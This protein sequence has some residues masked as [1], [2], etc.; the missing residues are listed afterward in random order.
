[1]T[2]K[3]N[4]TNAAR[5]LDRAHISYRLIP[6][7]V[8]PD[9]LAADHVAAELGEPIERVFKTIVLKGMR[10]GH[11]VCVVPGNFEVSLKLAAEVMHDKSAEPI[12][13]KELQPLTGYIRGGCSPIGLKKPLP[14]F[15]HESAMQFDTIFI[16]AGMRGLQIEIAPADLVAYTGATVADVARPMTD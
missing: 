3:I 7:H 6:Y 9:N 10:N 8:D 13:V 5:L 12:H 14:I 16:S 11:F 15:I 4:K 2:D 1:M